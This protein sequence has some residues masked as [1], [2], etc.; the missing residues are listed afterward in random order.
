[1]NNKRDVWDVETDH[2]GLKVIF[3]K[4]KYPLKIE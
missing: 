2:D 1:M 4:L 3:P